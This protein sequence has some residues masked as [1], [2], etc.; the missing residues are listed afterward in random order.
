MVH[1]ARLQCVRGECEM[2]KIE[3]EIKHGNNGIDVSAG[4]IKQSATIGEQAVALRFYKA[5][6][7]IINTQKKKVK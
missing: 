6:N 5:I 1:R 7:R 3:I 4:H 2:I